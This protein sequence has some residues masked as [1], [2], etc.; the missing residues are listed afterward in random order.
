VDE[1]L[2]DICAELFRNAA[3]HTIL[4]YGSRADGTE[5][6]FSD[7]DIAAFAD[8]PVSKRD[9]RVVDGKFLD[10]FV[11]PEAV[12]RNPTK[13]HLTLRGS[14]ILSQRNFEATHFL[15]ALDVIF[16]TGPE[17]L[18]A[19][20][21]EARRTW[22]GKMALRMRRSDVEGNFRRAWLLT[23]LLEDYFALRG[24]WYQGPKK[25]FQW[26]RASDFET[27]AAFEEA[28]KPAS[29]F[30]AV[31]YLVER[32]VAITGHSRA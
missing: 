13:E 28:L 20:E 16:C 5:N 30:E 15:A 21:I 10:V 32:V 11:H 25:S 4:L 24:M 22:A 2:H 27:Y 3:A 6:E 23:A 17:H 7:Y 9:A 18:P 14:R 31:D 8:V 12:L 29:P 26:L 1:L 19:D